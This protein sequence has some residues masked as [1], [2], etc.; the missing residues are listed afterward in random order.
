MALGTAM[1]ALFLSLCATRW[2]GR[3]LSRVADAARALA[4]GDMTRRARLRQRDEIG[5]LA[6][7][8]DAMADSLAAK[9]RNCAA[10]PI[11]SSAASRRGRRN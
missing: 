6:D 7:A 4:S 1:V 5:Q 9:T 3:P 10:T 2:V 11:R 8:F